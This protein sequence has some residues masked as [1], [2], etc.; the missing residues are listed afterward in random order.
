MRDVTLYSMKNKSVHSCRFVH[1]AKFHCIMTTLKT[2]FEI[3]FERGELEKSRN[4]FDTGA[5]FNSPIVLTVLNL[6]MQNKLTIVNL[7]VFHTLHRKSSI[8]P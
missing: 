6:D 2:L 7:F 4:F 8:Q 5:L 1:H 3:K